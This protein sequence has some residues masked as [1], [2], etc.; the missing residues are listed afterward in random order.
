MPDE[1]FLKGFVEATEVDNKLLELIATSGG[2]LAPHLHMPLQSGA[3]PILRSMRR[4]HTREQY[5]SRALE[6]A[7]RVEPLGLGADIISGFPGETDA[8]HRATVDLVSELP[9]T[10]LHVFPFSARPNTAAFDLKGAPKP[11][12][13][14]ERR[15]ALSEAASEIGAS[16][17]RS[18]DGARETVVIEGTVGLSGRYQRVVVPMGEDLFPG[19]LI[20]VEETS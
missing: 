5:R 17:R 6:I 20:D 9:F 19:D 12:I 16:F 10:Y 13:V 14:R 1:D 8:D 3:N 15:A 11:E 2:Q 7:A 4:W 18:L